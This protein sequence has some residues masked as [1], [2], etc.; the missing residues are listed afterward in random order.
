[1]FKQILIFVLSITVGMVIGY[2]CFAERNTSTV[3]HGDSMIEKTFAM[4]KPDAVQ[5]KNSGKIID[6]I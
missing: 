6:M 1:M 5:A 3:I 4:I 2:W